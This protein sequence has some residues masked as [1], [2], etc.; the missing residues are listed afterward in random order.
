[1][2][3]THEPILVRGEDETIADMVYQAIG[4]A[5]VAWGKD[6]VFQDGF[7]KQIGDDLIAIIDE[8]AD[9]ET[10]RLIDHLEVAWGIIANASDWLFSE[11]DERGRWV[12][13]AQQWRDQYHEILRDLVVRS[14]PEETIEVGVAT[15]ADTLVI[16][17][18]RKGKYV[19][20]YGPFTS[21]E[22]GEFALA[23]ISQQNREGGRHEFILD[24]IPESLAELV[25]EQP[26]QPR[27]T[28]EGFLS[29]LDTFAEDP[30]SIFKS[31][32]F[33]TPTEPQWSTADL[34]QRDRFPRRALTE[35]D[36]PFPSDPWPTAAR[37]RK[38]WSGD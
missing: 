26:E 20:S 27:T 32:V 7:A 34:D 19:R 14:E 3:V 17:T 4:A 36:V 13:Y 8:Q 23:K 30:N 31:S 10:S 12:P 28:I 5:S 35:D 16:E 38:P 2:T 11:E 1:V 24:T 22:A 29:F 9:A 37:H 15:L 21:Y 33:E 6:G 25:I 18:T